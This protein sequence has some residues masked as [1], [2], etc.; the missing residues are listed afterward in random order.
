M[1]L[2]FH[3]ISAG[4]LQMTHAQASPQ[5]P[6]CVSGGGPTRDQE[7]PMLHRGDAVVHLW[8]GTCVSWTRGSTLEDFE[9]EIKKFSEH[10]GWGLL[11]KNLWPADLSS[12]CLYCCIEKAKPPIFHLP[13]GMTIGERYKIIKWI[14]QEPDACTAFPL[15]SSAKHLAWAFVYVCVCARKT[16]HC[17]VCFFFFF[18]SPVSIGSSVS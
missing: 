8:E 5:V 14:L 16:L 3:N 11:L 6:P 7:S 13:D 17:V 1:E 4:K 15:R 18:F 12:F 10:Q 9:V 2:W